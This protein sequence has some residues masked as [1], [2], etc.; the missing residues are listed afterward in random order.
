MAANPGYCAACGFAGDV[1]EHHI[2][3]KGQGGRALP[4]VSTYMGCYRFRLWQGE[5]IRISARWRRMLVWIDKPAAFLPYLAVVGAA[6]GEYQEETVMLEPRIIR[7]PVKVGILTLVALGIIAGESGSAFA[8]CDQSCQASKNCRA[9][10]HGTKLNNDARQK[11]FQKCTLDPT[12]YKAP[13][14]T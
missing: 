12:K 2:V 3:P 8:A 9:M 11:E 1:H 14:G 6:S 4:T 10:L 5:R 13:T 7:W